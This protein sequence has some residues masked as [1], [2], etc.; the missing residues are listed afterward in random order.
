MLKKS[1]I[2]TK[3]SCN[4]NNFCIVL[5]FVT[6]V[7]CQYQVLSGFKPDITFDDR[8]DRFDVKS[9]ISYQNKYYN[10]DIPSNR[11]SNSQKK[12][13]KRIKN[14]AKHITMK[15]RRSLDDIYAID[16]KM[17]RNDVNSIENVKIKA[18]DFAGRKSLN[19]IFVNLHDSKRRGSD[20]VDESSNKKDIFNPE[21][22]TV[23]NYAFPIHMIVRGFLLPPR[24]A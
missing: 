2:L 24:V 23:L 18:D 8:N 12:S 7:E 6:A 20:V 21:E 19:D 1:T 17:D 13:Q 10:D 16:N 15:R 22:D 9:L 5:Y 3:N 4:M 11:R 14:V